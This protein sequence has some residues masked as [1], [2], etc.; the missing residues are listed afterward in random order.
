M[1]TEEFT[2]KNKKQV[3]DYL[4]K[5]NLDCPYPEYESYR[6]PSSH[7]ACGGEYSSMHY[8]LSSVFKKIKNK[9]WRVIVNRSLAMNLEK[10]FI[11][12]YQLSAVHDELHKTDGI[13][14]H[15]Y[16][17]GHRNWFHGPFPGGWETFARI[18][19]WD[20]PNCYWH[21]VL[22]KGDLKRDKLL[23]K[24]Y[25]TYVR[26]FSEYYPNSYNPISEKRKSFHEDL[27]ELHET[28]KNILL[29]IVS[30]IEKKIAAL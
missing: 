1:S 14:T 25:E 29:K 2:A 28:L 9:P 10:M 16:P 8:A 27:R 7:C 19:D 21:W 22:K 11:V 26:V 4:K 17:S 13:M 3:I 5:L 6:S 15:M 12:G 23:V 24:A 18:W 20:S 30:R